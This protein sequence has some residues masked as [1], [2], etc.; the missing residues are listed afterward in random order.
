MRKAA[1]RYGVLFAAVVLIGGG[2]GL[3]RASV[4]E[5]NGIHLA[6]SALPAVLGPI[7]ARGRAG[8]DCVP[9]QAAAA[10]SAARAELPTPDH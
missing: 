5:L 9:E 3:A 8:W 1:G 6:P 4:D 2:A 7:N 10:S